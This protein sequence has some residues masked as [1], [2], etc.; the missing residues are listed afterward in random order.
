M[1]KS[2]LMLAAALPFMFAACGSEDPEENFNLETTALEIDYEKTANIETSVNGCTFTSD[3]E[4]IATVDKDGKVTANHVGE[5]NITVAYNGESATCKVTVKPTLMAYT[6]PVI[7]WSLNLSQVE[8]QVKVNFPALVKDPTSTNSELGYYST[9]E[10]KQDYPM[11]VYEFENNLLKT[12]I[13]LISGAMDKTNS[14]DEWLLQYYADLGETTYGML[15][16]NAADA[17]DASVLVELQ[18]DEENDEYNAA[19]VE[20]KGSKTVRGG[21]IIDRTYIEKGREFARKMKNN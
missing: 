6:M 19:W 3:N 4:F 12:S 18:Y 7:D 14:I 1:K 5:A 15:Y 17:L 21:M 8:D 2:V 13:L 10:G 9:T 16:G 11:Y 20:N